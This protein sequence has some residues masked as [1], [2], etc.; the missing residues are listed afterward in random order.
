MDGFGPATFGDLNAED[1]D[2]LHD[3]GTTDET[4]DLI[5]DLAGEGA[6]LLE[7]AIGSGRIALPLAARGFAISG[8]EAS[9]QM[10]ALMRQ[11]SGGED[12]PVIIGDM[13]EARV[14]ASFDFAFLVFNTL[15]NLTSQ[16]AQVN[17]FANAARHL[18]PGGTF[19][20]ETFVP[21]LD[22][23]V[24][25][26]NVR[27]MHLDMSSVWLEA[28]IHNPVTQVIEMQRIRITAEGM[29]LVPLPMRYA[30]VPEIDLMAR[31]AGFSLVARWGGWDRSPFTA[32]SGMHIS[33][34]RLG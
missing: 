29:K 20:V 6:S 26:Q 17:L 34:Y 14:E 22:G 7:F 13:A 5:A 23:F 24:N 11:K 1:Y 25:N 33:V 4:V 21:R 32:Q 12:V 16:D 27:T 8:I 30:H 19:L 9:E 3:P 2:S 31:L 28:A 15:F 18:K 10:V